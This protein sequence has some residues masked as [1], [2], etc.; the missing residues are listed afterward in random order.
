M[1]YFQ[2]QS[3]WLEVQAVVGVLSIAVALLG[4]EYAPLLKILL[5]LEQFHTELTGHIDCV[6]LIRSDVRIFMGAIII[7]GICRLCVIESIPAYRSSCT[8]RTAKNILH[9][10]PKS[11]FQIFIIPKGIQSYSILID[12]SVSLDM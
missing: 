7:I 12:M 10:I 2:F 1:L 4:H 6:D 9:F 8:P 5:I 11:H 3:Y